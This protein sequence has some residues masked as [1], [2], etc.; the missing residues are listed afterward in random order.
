MVAFENGAVQKYNMSTLEK[1]GQSM[2][3]LVP[4]TSRVAL[5]QIKIDES[6]TVA[7]I[8]QDGSVILCRQR[9]PNGAYMVI[10]QLHDAKHDAV[11]ILRQRVEFLNVTDESIVRS[12]VLSKPDQIDL[13]SIEL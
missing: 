13:V 1:L 3:Q 9:K 11:P 4:K 2:Q 5:K 6:D 7:A 8:F 12:L 10:T